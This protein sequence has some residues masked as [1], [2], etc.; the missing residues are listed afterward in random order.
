MT[1]ADTLQGL[2]GIKIEISKE[3]LRTLA[4]YLIS[5]GEQQVQEVE[6]MLTLE[7]VARI[8]RRDKATLIRWHK[9]GVLKHNHINLY[10]SSEVKAFLNK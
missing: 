5:Y 8:V 10:K 3:D 9:S 1:I 7:E 6:K 4:A 2:P